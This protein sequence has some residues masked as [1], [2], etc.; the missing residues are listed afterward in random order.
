MEMEMA[1]SPPYPATTAALGGLPTIGVDVPICA[2]FLVLYMI[3]AASHMTILQ[4]NLKKGHKFLISG[5]IFGFCMSRI[6]TT[7][8]RITWAVY[9]HNARLAIAANIFV[10]AGI[11]LLFI[12]NLLFAQRVI[13]AAHPNAGWH[14]IFH[15]L[16][17]AIYVIIVLT[18]C[19][20]IASVV[21]QSYT[22]DMNA[23]RIDHDIQLYG[24]TYYAVVSFLPI[25]LVIGG[26][27]IPRK[28]RVEKFGSGRFRHKIAILLLAAVL[29]C[30]GASFRAGTNYAGGKR[31]RTDPASYQNK[32]CFYVFNFTVEV[33][34]IYLYVV[35]RVDKRFHVPNKSH[36][37]GDYSR[38]LE[39]SGAEKSTESTEGMHIA[40][41]ENVFD[42]KR[43]DDLGRSDSERDKVVD[44]E[45]GIPN[46]LETVHKE[47][48]AGQVS[49]QRVLPVE[50]E[51]KN[52]PAPAVAEFSPSS[53][54]PPTPPRTPPPVLHQ[55]HET[56]VQMIKD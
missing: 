36:G 11:V 37:P 6:V 8:L 23:K 38:K 3:G 54:T 17:V 24:G 22:L 51:T 56:V 27:I 28:T 31:P 46:E 47:I 18:L 12:V 1:M 14:P 10:Q 43:P 34:V 29:L 52:E 35:V 16:F 50:Q 26:L 13:R 33:L 44:E 25:P 42:D 20:L 32:A 45:K 49:E 19:A 4:I 41:E 53:Q 7:V 30:A 9:P 40:S 48:L 15:Y 5:M 39:E 2:V 21:Q 55:P